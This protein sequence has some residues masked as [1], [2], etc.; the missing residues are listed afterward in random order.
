M[1]AVGLLVLAQ[2]GPLVR[3]AVSEA[4]RRDLAVIALPMLIAYVLLWRRRQDV[5][6][7]GSAIRITH[8]LLVSLFGIGWAASVPDWLL[9][10]GWSVTLA[11][12]TLV[13]FGRSLARAMIFPCV[14]LTLVGLADGASRSY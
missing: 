7:E 3:L 9:G 1:R 14:G 2:V 13:L 8:V 10:A 6:R 12:A 4:G 5:W 11:A